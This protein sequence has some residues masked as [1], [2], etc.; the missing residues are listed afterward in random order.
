M[1]SKLELLLLIITNDVICYSVRIQ[2]RDTHFSSLSYTQGTARGLNEAYERN[3]ENFEG[4]T[5]F[6]SEQRCNTKGNTCQAELSTDASLNEQ[7]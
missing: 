3:L 2:T 1:F 7:Y 6:Q 5:P 4:F